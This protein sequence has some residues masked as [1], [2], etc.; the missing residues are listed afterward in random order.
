M[1]TQ[2]NSVNPKL[3]DTDLPQNTFLILKHPKVL[4]KKSHQTTEEILNVKCCFSK[5]FLFLFLPLAI[6]VSETESLAL[7]TNKKHIS[8]KEHHSNFIPLQ[9]LSKQL[10]ISNPW[11]QEILELV[12][13]RCT[14]FELPLH[15]RSGNIHLPQVSRVSLESYQ[16]KQ[17]SEDKQESK[18]WKA[19]DLD[20]RYRSI[21]KLR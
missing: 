5:F 4:K 7:F 8:K 10:M 6:S 14:C 21:E 13:A 19:L 15:S 12:A 17:D 3:G 9:H 16:N 1:N 11:D 18:F 20:A 2:Q